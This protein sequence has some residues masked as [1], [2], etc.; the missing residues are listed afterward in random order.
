M[1]AH[2]RNREHQIQ[3]R[4]ERVKKQIGFAEAKIRHVQEDRASGSHLQEQMELIEKLASNQKRVED[5]KRKQ[6]KDNRTKV[7]EKLE[8]EA[9]TI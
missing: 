6:E 1:R 8:L 4:V 3:E 2:D 9:L 7:H 5:K